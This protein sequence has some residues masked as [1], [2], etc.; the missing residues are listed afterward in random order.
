MRSSLYHT[1]STHK[2]IAVIEN[3]VCMIWAWDNKNG[4]KFHHI[5]SHSN[6][7]TFDFCQIKMFSVIQL[8]SMNYIL[9]LH[10]LMTFNKICSFDKMKIPFDWIFYLKNT[11]IKYPI[12]HGVAYLKK[13]SNISASR[14]CKPH[15][16]GDPFIRW[17]SQGS[18]AKLNGCHKSFSTS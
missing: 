10:S 14:Y 2:N 12:C 13:R 17:F 5:P 15:N 9:S 16:I 4:P 8:Y 1:I 11:L 18:F 3:L 6:T 7:C